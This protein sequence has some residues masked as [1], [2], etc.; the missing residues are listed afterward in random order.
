MG[1]IPITTIIS[2]LMFFVQLFV[3]DKARQ[4]VIRENMLSWINKKSTK[5]SEI[6]DGMT[7]LERQE[8]ELKALRKEENDSNGKS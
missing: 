2:I 7:D 1:G 5:G 4:Q 6:A 3:K 8:E